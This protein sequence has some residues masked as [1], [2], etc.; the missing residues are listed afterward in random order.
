MWHSWTPSEREK[1][2]CLHYKKVLEA[3]W[4]WGK[5]CE[6]RQVRK[7]DALSQAMGYKKLIN[8]RELINGLCDW[9]G[10][11]G[12]ENNFHITSKW[13]DNGEGRWQSWNGPFEFEKPMGLPLHHWLLIL[14]MLTKL[15][16][17]TTECAKKLCRLSRTFLE[18]R[19]GSWALVRCVTWPWCHILPTPSPPL[20]HHYLNLWCHRLV[21]A[22]SVQYMKAIVQCMHSF[23]S[24]HMHF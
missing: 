17:Y 2:L 20:G 19:Q 12:K 18:Y 6:I 23:V 4:V 7:A 11:R 3:E 10:R 1:S 24:V 8:S 21:L 16:L 14:S 13:A 15:W 22:T 5:V 9:W